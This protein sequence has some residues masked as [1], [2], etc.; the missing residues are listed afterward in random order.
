MERVFKN[1]KVIDMSFIPELKD[2]KF[3]KGS[4]P[5]GETKMT[6]RIIIDYP[7]NIKTPDKKVMAMTP[8]QRS[9]I[10]NDHI[11]KHT[12]PVIRKFK[13]TDYKWIKP[14]KH[15]HGIE[16]K[17]TL[18]VYKKLKKVK[19]II[20]HISRISGG[21]KIIKKREGGIWGGFF[22]VKVTIAIQIEKA[23]KGMQTW[24]ERY[25]LIKAKSFD[26]AFNKV[27]KNAKNYTSGPYINPYGQLV[28][29]KIESYDDCYHTSI[30][31]PKQLN[32][33]E[34]VEV[35]STLKLRKMTKDRYWNGKVK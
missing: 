4:F 8:T 22:C 21:K 29:W 34:G 13:L 25:I 30:Y 5:N 19:T 3:K 12:N 33:E 15:L 24:E 35:F 17:T 32:D 14:D 28:R 26:D 27:E 20:V 11:I 31:N 9:K 18:D 7:S 10:I 23:K 2:W 1:I 16:L 6:V